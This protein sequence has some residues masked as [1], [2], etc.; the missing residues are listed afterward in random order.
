MPEYKPNSH[1]YRESQQ[2]TAAT[3]EKRVEKVVKGAVKTKKKGEVRKLAEVFVPGDVKNVKS[4][5]V[6]DVLVPAIKKAI[7]DIV[8]NGIDMILYGETGRSRKRSSSDYVSYSRYSDSKR[9]DRH[10]SREA[11]RPRFDYDDI[12]YESRGEAEAVL[13][14]MLDVIDRY[15]FITVG[16]MYDMAGLPQPYTSNKYGWTSL[17]TAET[18]RTRDGYTIK[19]PKAMPID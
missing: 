11:T 1:K 3:E 13:E 14:Q 12:I 2:Q 18:V 19:L 5:V 4:Y 16:D 9:D 10:T 15:K 6:M 7:S 8:T 17:R